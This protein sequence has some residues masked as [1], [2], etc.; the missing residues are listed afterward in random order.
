MSQLILSKMAGSWEGICRTWF[1]PGKL[2]D[3]SSIKGIISPVV[4]QAF[5]HHSYQSSIKGN[6]RLGQEWI[7][8]NPIRKVFQVSWI[9]DFHMSYAIMHSEGAA[10]SDGFSVL[11]SYDVG[12]EDPPWGWR[13]TYQLDSDSLLTI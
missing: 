7:A 13:T 4:N 12:P 9:D 10:T 5:M 6:P 2:E 1:E 11:G 8:F 3:E